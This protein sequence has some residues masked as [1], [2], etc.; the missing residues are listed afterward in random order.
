MTLEPQHQGNP[1]FLTAEQY[2]NKKLA[3]A[4]Y[5]YKRHKGFFTML[6]TTLAEYIGVAELLHFD[7]P[8]A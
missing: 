1:T 6:L 8:L 3:R 7:M 2:F 5:N 4:F